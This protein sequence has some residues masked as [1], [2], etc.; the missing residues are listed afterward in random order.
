MGTARFGRSSGGKARQT[1]ISNAPSREGSEEM[2]LKAST[3]LRNAELLASRFFL[4]ALVSSFDAKLDSGA[5][6]L[7][8]FRGFSKLVK[9]A[10]IHTPQASE[11]EKVKA[12]DETSAGLLRP[13]AL[14]REALALLLTSSRESAP[15]ASC[16]R[17]GCTARRFQRGVVVR[18]T[19]H[20][21]RRCPANRNLVPRN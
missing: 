13:A 5:I 15:L 18:L 8:G 6:V 21:M 10:A 7:C 9:A 14:E 12:A 19:R 2:T 3:A 4:S 16:Q 1:S 17:S 11:K 20:E